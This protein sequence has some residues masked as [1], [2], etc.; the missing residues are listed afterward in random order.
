[1][2][3]DILLEK[4]GKYFASRKDV[5]FAYLFGSVAKDKSHS[6]SDVDIG[7]YFTPQDRALEYESTSRY[8]AES[9]IWSDLDQLI[10]RHTDMVV[11]NRAPSTLFSAVLEEGKKI[12]SNNDGLLHRLSSAVNDL[13][14]D[15]RNFITDFVMIKERSRS[16]KEDTVS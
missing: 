15:F 7:V 6:E 1:M 14:I 9:Q 13:A 5:A 16:L 10:G 2:N 8:P 12:F 11:L 3:K 4:L